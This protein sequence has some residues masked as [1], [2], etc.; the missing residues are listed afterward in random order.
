[1]EVERVVVVVWNR[2]FAIGIVGGAQIFAQNRSQVL[3]TR[4][5]ARN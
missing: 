3:S 2:A 5:R 4:V 1:V